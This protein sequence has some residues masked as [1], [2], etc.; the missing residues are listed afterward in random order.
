[1]IKIYIKREPL[2]NFKIQETESY[3][4]ICELI[5]YKN[6]YEEIKNNVIE[7]IFIEAKS[8]SKFREYIR[9][10]R[11]VFNNK[12]EKV[13]NLLLKDYEIKEKFEEL[14][15]IVSSI[16]FI[17]NEFNQTVYKD[18]EKQFEQI[19]KLLEENQE[20]TYALHSVNNNLF[21]PES[22]K[23]GKKYYYTLWNYILRAS[24]KNSPLSLFNKVN[25]VTNNSMNHFR[26]TSFKFYNKNNML[27]KS[28]RIQ[29]NQY[30]YYNEKLYLHYLKS[31][32]IH[33][34]ISDNS[35]KIVVIDTDISIQSLL[36]QHF[37]EFQASKF[38]LLVEEKAKYTRE[39]L[40]VTDQSETNGE[41]LEDYISLNEVNEDINIKVEYKLIKFLN[42]FVNTEG[43][44]ENIIEF[45]KKK[46]MKEVPFI[47]FLKEV[48]EDPESIFKEP[49]NINTKIKNDFLNYLS[50]NLDS[51]IIM[52]DKFI[53]INFD[54]IECDCNLS[55]T[56]HIQKE[57][58]TQVINSIYGGHY[59]HFSRYS[60]IKDVEKEI[61][62]HYKT[63]Y[64]FTEV[65]EDFNFT[66]AVHNQLTPKRVRYTY[67]EN[68]INVKDLFICHSGDNISIKSDDVQ[69]TPIFMS[70]LAFH[71]LPL[72]L[73]ILAKF[74]GFDKIQFN[75][76]DHFENKI[77]EKHL[78]IPRI[79][80]KKSILSRKK[81][82][83]KLDRIKIESMV[84]WYEYLKNL[85]NDYQELKLFYFKFFNSKKFEITKPQIGSV[86]NILSLKEMYKQIKKFDYLIL[87]EQ[88]PLDNCAEYVIQKGYTYD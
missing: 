19:N 31:N 24:Y 5:H 4:K 68:D 11:Y 62:D 60:Y 59:S 23:K 18:E 9:L 83:I 46:S 3:R 21:N 35:E 55:M 58:D 87:E 48:T 36:N 86:K 73:K 7:L 44:R 45:M 71:H 82:L 49:L 42:I 28:K 16:I 26:L 10:K 41:Y 40:K 37:D 12:Y 29:N 80:F 8:N 88:F 52:I 75:I 1:M 76:I 69:I 64:L 72:G 56:F 43:Y 70:P 66:P 47:K 6:L 53:D 33:P 32:K 14:F 74:H 30:I 63:N 67:S 51:D 2:L 77:K 84:D 65:Y 15:E 81:I 54:K 57:N 38:G 25:I 13:Y 27:K 61:I 17:T 50:N 34:N 39:D 85:V 79:Q 78:V 22:Y 20:F